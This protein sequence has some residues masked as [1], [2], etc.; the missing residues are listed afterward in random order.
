MARP[1]A[2]LFVT[3]LVDLLRPNIGFAALKLLE[4]AGCE[5]AVPGAQTCCGQPAYNSGARLEAAAIARQTIAAFE[6]FDYVVAPSGSCAGM[7]RV[8][9]PALLADDKAWAARAEN[10]AGRCF[11]LFDFLVNVRGMT[12][13]AARCDVA[14]AYHDSCSSLR[15]IKAADAPRKL[16]ASVSGMTLADIPDGES[17]C[18]FGGA[19]CVKYPEVS[20]RIGTDKLDCA[21]RTGARLVLAG[22][23][24]CLLH[25]AGLAAR[26]NRGLEFRHAAEVLAGE[27]TTPPMGR[28][29]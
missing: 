20:A 4:Q 28:G 23:L 13:V 26:Q 2:G 17:C 15:E 24:G 16:L 19:F 7:L 29:K 12:S 22:D 18:G 27:M 9:Y 14:A 5:V 3:C 21:A 1:K 10:F 11:E 25:M 6:D 8:H